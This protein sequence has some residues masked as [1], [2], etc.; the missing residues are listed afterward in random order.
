MLYWNWLVYLIVIYMIIST[1]HF[2]ATR[3]AKVGKE[4]KGGSLAKTRMTQ[5]L[6][7]FAG[8]GKIVADGALLACDCTL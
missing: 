7:S 5:M 8:L 1:M 4:M 6:Y 2:S 3:H